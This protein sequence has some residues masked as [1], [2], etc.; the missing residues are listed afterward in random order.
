V[1]AP[2]FTNWHPKASLR[3]REEEKQEDEE[4]E[5]Q[6]SEQN[7]M[8]TP[9]LEAKPPSEFVLEAVRPATSSLQLSRSEESSSSENRPQSS[10]SS[11]LP[12][13]RPLNYVHFE[14]TPVRKNSDLTQF[15][16]A[17]KKNSYLM[18][19]AL[20]PILEE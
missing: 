13:G 18:Q 6:E 19:S 12:S 8:E 15:V 11:Q 16:E 2:S 14:A 20:D 3:Y 5:E 1:A 17:S 10:D 7:Q 4:A 9:S